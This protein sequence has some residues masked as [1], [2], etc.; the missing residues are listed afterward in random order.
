MRLTRFLSIVAT[1]C[2]ALA[3]PTSFAVGQTDGYPTISARS[4]T[5]GSATVSVK[6]AV[7][8]DQEIAIN[9]QASI[10]DG[11]MTW[12]QFGVSGADTPNALIT[13]GNGEVGVSLGRG[14][15]VVTT[16]IAP[17]EPPQCAGST[18]VTGAS[19]AGHYACPGVVSYDAASGKMG[20][21]DVEVR[22]TAKS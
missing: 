12:L 19:V 11:E 9:T 16:G 18:T 22:F 3:A 17:G 20:K 10:G 8:F 21:V 7:K 13:Y 4:F 2:L 1:A 5:G 14:K 6:G 15:F